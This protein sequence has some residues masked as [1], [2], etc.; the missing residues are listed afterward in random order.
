MNMYFTSFAGEAN[1]KESYEMFFIHII[2]CVTRLVLSPHRHSSCCWHL[3]STA[4]EM[5]PFCL[6]NKYLKKEWV[7]RKAYIDHM[8]STFQF[9]ISLAFFFE[10]W[11]VTCGKNDLQKEPAHFK[12]QGRKHEDLH[13]SS[14]ELFWSISPLPTAFHQVLLIQVFHYFLVVPSSD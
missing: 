2:Y 12:A 4:I 14:K 5:L 8:S 7:T 1:V 11:E 13:W 6:W 3:I 10:T 9:I